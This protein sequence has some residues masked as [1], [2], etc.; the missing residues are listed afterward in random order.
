MSPPALNRKTAERNSS[1]DLASASALIVRPATIARVAMVLIA[2]WMLDLFVLKTSLL[3]NCDGQHALTPLYVFWKPRVRATAVVFPIAFGVF[4]FAANRLCDPERTRRRTFTLLL[5]LAAMALPFALFLVRDAPSALGAQFTLYPDDEFL[6]DA[7]VI[8]DYARFLAHYVELM[9]RLSLH[10]QHFPPGHASLLYVVARVFGPST[11]AAGIAVLAIFAA[12]VCVAFLALREIAGERGARQ[13]ACLVLAA[14]SML[15]FA[16]TG[17]D[18]VFF[19]LAAIAFWLGLR[20]FKDG[21]R[22]F[23]A[24]L[25]GIALLVATFFSFSTLPLGFVI[26]VYALVSGRTRMPRTLQ[27]LAILG[28][29]FVSA[30][31]LLKATTGF[32]VWDALFQARRSAAEF[33]AQVMNGRAGT[34]RWHLSYGNAVAFAFGAGIALTAA[35]ITAIAAQKRSERGLKGHPWSIAALIAIA[36][37]SF[38]PIYYMETERIWM[39]AIPWVAG[40]TVLCGAVEARSLRFLLVVSAAQAFLMEIALFTLW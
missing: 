30:A 33:M 8:R 21:A 3:A 18:A 29:T 31:L 14:P 1:P 39:F 17:M 32:A 15:D 27:R 34:D 38:A 40:I 6:H 19:T 7:G 16:C 36:T 2:L 26:G 37:M 10:G 13:A 28:A 25:C 4:A 12:G 5:A 11:L 35:A 24:A 20:A 9:P 23:D 22:W